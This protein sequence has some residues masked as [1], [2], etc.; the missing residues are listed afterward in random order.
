M[1]NKQFLPGVAYFCMEYG[2]HEELPIYSG[3]LGILA[4]DHIK[5][6]GEKNLP[7]VG[8]GILWRQGYTTQLIDD[9]GKPY[10]VFKD[11][12]LD[13][14]KDVK[15]TVNVKI[16]D[17]DILCKIWLV[18]KYGNAPLYLLDA[19]L[20]EN[21]ENRYITN[22]LYCGSE[23]DRIA[24]EIILG[25]GGIRA[26]RALGIEVDVYHFNEGHAVL[27]AVELIR[28][29]MSWGLSF[30]EAWYKTRNQV[31]FTTHTPVTAGNGVYGH[32][33]L[34]CTGA[35]NGLSYEQM[36]QIGGDPFSI[37]VAGLNLSRKTNAV[38]KTHSETAKKMWGH[39]KDASPIIPITNGVH[40]KTWQDSEI[41]E[42]FENGNDLWESHLKAKKELV[43]EIY[44][45]NNKNKLN[46][47]SLIIGFARRITSYKRCDL[48]FKNAELLEPLLEEGKIQLL[49]SGKAHPQDEE[50]KSVLPRIIE[51]SNKYPHSVAFLENYDMKIGKL[52]T[53]GCDAWLN[54]PRRP[55]EASG[56]SGMKAAMNGVLN[57]S[58]L[59]GWWPEACKHGIN[60]W[61]I[62][63]GH[64]CCNQDEHDA[65]SLYQVL[66]REVIPTYYD[67]KPKWLKMMRNSIAASTWRFSAERMLTEYYYKM[68]SQEEALKEIAATISNIHNVNYI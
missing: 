41:I 35:Y 6:A 28:E 14:L 31:V 19:N 5:C 29:K 51:M 34:G 67:N 49:F 20:S 26:L 11:I 4:G 15:V 30:E 21:G 54:N 38:S 59:D 47:D 55:L 25:I 65:N 62:G 22:R 13:N 53:R 66:L 68:Y 48:I 42:A 8:I 44:K 39:I 63:H 56:T 12:D 52:L 64:E 61:Q 45:R 36:S 58:I 2:L 3:G 1:L 23:H 10:D 50:G 9:N 46:P 40:R 16:G 18:D 17:K 60:G 43:N 32:H 24:Q 7:L 33:A 57:L 37:T 27:G